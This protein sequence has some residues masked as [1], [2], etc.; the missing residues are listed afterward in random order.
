MSRIHRRWLTLFAVMTVIVLV[1]VMR[2]ILARDGTPPRLFDLFDTFIVLASFVVLAIGWRKLSRSDWLVGFGAGLLV[3]VLLPFSTLYNPYPFFEIATDLRG[4]AVING[5]MTMVT[6]MGGLVIMHWGGPVRVTITSLGW[7]QSGR[8]LLFGAVIG[9]PFAVLN[10][11]ANAWTQNRPIA[12]QNPLAAVV[13]AIHPAVIEEV[14][15]R[16]AL[17]GLLWLLFRRDWPSRQAIVLAGLLAV[18]IHTYSHYS[19]L[20]L[21]QPLTAL[22]MGA[23][24]GLIWGIPPTL[25]AIQR[26]LESAMSFHWI[27]DVIRF[28]LGF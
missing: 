24:M 18:L 2:T 9:L 1:F 6:A 14:I 23:V 15:Y 28:G 4:R 13:D 26:D 8:S 12:W 5:I 27:Q 17:L 3:G 11:F 20:F 7:R 22:G 10:G 19:D 25:L 16:L 21:T